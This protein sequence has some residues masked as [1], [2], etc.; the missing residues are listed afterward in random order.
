MRT[1]L[2]KYTTFGMK[3][4][5]LQTTRK[6]FGFGVKHKEKANTILEKH[7]EVTKPF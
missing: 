4:P 5:F 2:V 7:E 3:L 1:L 6:L